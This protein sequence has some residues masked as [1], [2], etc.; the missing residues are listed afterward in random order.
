MRETDDLAHCCAL[1]RYAISGHI[2]MCAVLMMLGDSESTHRG[3]Q[4]IEFIGNG[5]REN[6]TKAQSKHDLRPLLIADPHI[7][8]IQ[9]PLT[10]W[11][12]DILKFDLHRIHL[13]ANKI[14]ELFD[15]LCL[16]GCC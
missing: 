9:L 15:N 13:R 6:V 8:A 4:T 11:H 1:E 14:A 10:R 12:G 2:T 16:R 7:E 3:C 5:R